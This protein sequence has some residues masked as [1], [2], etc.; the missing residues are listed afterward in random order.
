M[1][2]DRCAATCAR[3]RF[4]FIDALFRDIYIRG[5]EVEVRLVSEDLRR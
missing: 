4:E 2:Y 5:C 3:S 1:F